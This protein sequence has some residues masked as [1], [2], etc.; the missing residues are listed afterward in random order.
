LEE[1]K[2]AGIKQLIIDPGFGFGKT[3]ANNY[4]L[5]KNLSKFNSTYD[6][7]K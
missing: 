4:E 6:S 2:L 1:C 3:I 7:I 5:V